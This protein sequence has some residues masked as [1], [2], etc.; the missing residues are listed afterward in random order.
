MALK[1]I[2]GLGWLGEMTR[3]DMLAF[4]PAAGLAG[5]WY[6]MPGALL[7][8]SAAV[9][10][11]WMARDPANAAAKP[12][13]TIDPATQL[14]ARAVAEAALDEALAICAESNHS[15]AAF[16]VGLDDAETLARTH[17]E[18]DYAQIL[19]RTAERLH[20]ALREY[21]TV[22]SLGGGR[23]GVALAAVRRAD[24]ESVLQIAARLQSSVEVPISLDTRAVYLSAHVGFC[25]MSRAP[26]L[27]GAAMLGAAETAADEAL[28]FGPGSIRAY[29]D[30]IRHGARERSDQ[31]DAVCAALEDGQ[32]VAHFLPQLS[33]DTGAV[34]GFELVPCWLHPAQGFLDAADF[35]PAVHAA[36]MRARL[37]EVLLYHGF[38]AARGWAKL[39]LGTVTLTLPLSIDELR[40][41][42]LP[43]R[44][45]WELDRFEFTPADL[46][47]Q[48][49]EAATAD[50]AQEIIGHSLA[51]LSGIGCTIELCGFGAGPASI[52]AIRKCAVRR[53]RIE[54]EFV[55][56]VDS[57]PDQQAIVAAILSLAEQLKLETLADGVANLG[58]HSML[59][60]LGC[61][62]VQGPA[63]ARAMAYDDTIDWIERHR[64]KLRATP[65]AP[66]RKR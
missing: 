41:P 49:P 57:D 44:L 64:G 59:A 2:R 62:Y 39:G 53:L 38:S 60:Q 29:S 63:I 52:T 27:R 37:T 42:K 32:I 5:Y 36:G 11:A 20:D 34:S 17:G 58:E 15:T 30:E 55:A 46:R 25:L 31:A 23:F 47:L 61:G 18:A 21:D 10:V 16:V 3:R 33:S 6:G 65:R 51:A 28:R 45:K 35:M 54:R 50:P 14:P 40:D 8:V 66:R 19:R 22:A 4:V 12:L 48:L 13:P 7:V 26:G 1:Q 56:R 9:A 24:L 43:E